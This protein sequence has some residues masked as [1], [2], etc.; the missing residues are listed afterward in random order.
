MTITRWLAA[1]VVLMLVFVIGYLSGY[2]GGQETSDGRSLLIGKPENNTE[3]VEYSVRYTDKKSSEVID[4]FLM[5]YSQSE[6][7]FPE[8]IDQSS[9][10]IVLSLN[11]DSRSVR[12][13]DVRLWFSDNSAIIGHKRSSSWHFRKITKQDTDYLK[14]LATW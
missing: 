13:L 9:P 12:L 11:N 4:R 7:T 3:K 8:N 14:K 6:P 1:V 2:A 10:D 5:I